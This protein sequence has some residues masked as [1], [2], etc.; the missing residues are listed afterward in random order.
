MSS[1]ESADNDDDDKYSSY[2]PSIE[3]SYQPLDISFHPTR[4]NLV[5]A[6]LVDGS[7]ECVCVMIY[8]QAVCYFIS[9]FLIYCS[10]VYLISLSYYIYFSSLFNF[11]AN[12]IGQFMIFEKT[13]TTTQKL[14]TMNMSLYWRHCPYIHHHHR[15]RHHH[16]IIKINIRIIKDH[17]NASH[18]L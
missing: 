16:Q 6:A 11:H 18:F 3:T 5:A 13:I 4:E 14:K 12:R 9:L 1:K 8:M 10:I 15:R 7:L 17:V 2:V